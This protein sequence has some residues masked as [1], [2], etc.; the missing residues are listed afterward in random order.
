MSGDQGHIPEPEVVYHYTTVDSMIKIVK[1]ASIWA[2]SINYLNDISERDHYLG[3][4][5]QRIPV[6]LK[7][8]EVADPAVFEK[9]SASTSLGFEARPFVGSFSRD[10]DSLPQWR[11]YCSNGNGVSIGFRVECLR[12]AFV[13]TDPIRQGNLAVNP[14]VNFMPIEYLGADSTEVIDIDIVKAIAAAGVLAKQMNEET[15]DRYSAA[16]YLRALLERR[17]CLVKHPSFQNEHEYRLL[18]DGVFRNLHLLDFRTTR[19][20][21]VPY[22][23]VCIPKRHSS[24]MQQPEPVTPL[25]PLAGRWDF[26]DRV[27]V[28]PTANMSL[29]IEA[30]SSF[31]RREMLYVEVVPSGVPYRDW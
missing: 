30:V 20:S 26:V 22:V 9:L 6:L 8:R 15:G 5:Q 12:R 16:D 19:S 17:A 11:S 1:S 14:K 28:G 7:S 29:T 24:V 25:S 23:A 3:L 13:N 4:V 2:T 18:V 31:F 10:S 21:L 27:V